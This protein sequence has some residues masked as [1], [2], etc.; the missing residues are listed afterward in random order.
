M[1]DLVKLKVDVKL[2][3]HLIKKINWSSIFKDNVPLM[4]AIIKSFFDSLT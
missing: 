4:N 2:M 1:T 3:D